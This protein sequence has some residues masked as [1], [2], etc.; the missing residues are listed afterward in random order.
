MI[1][2]LKGKNLFSFHELERT[3]KKKGGRLKQV[4]QQNSLS[5]LFYL[6]VLYTKIFINSTYY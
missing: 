1:A 4:T 2:K 6:M 5:F 3:E